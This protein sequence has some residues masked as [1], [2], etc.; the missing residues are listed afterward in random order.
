MF[1]QVEEREAHGGVR[2]SL[3]DQ[4]T[5]RNR[6]GDPGAGHEQQRHPSPA[7]QSLYTCTADESAASLL[8]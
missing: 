1:V 5:G 4:H 6:S 7:E 8:A 3:P 2:G